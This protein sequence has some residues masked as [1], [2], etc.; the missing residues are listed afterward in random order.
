VGLAVLARHEAVRT[1]V[2]RDDY[3]RAAGMIRCK[4]AAIGRDRKKPVRRRKDH[5]GLA[6]LVEHHRPYVAQ[7]VPQ[8]V[9]RRL[10]NRSKRLAFRMPLM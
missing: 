1:L 10:R 3:S 6:E 4:H 8:H 7:D 2:E 9:E 5:L